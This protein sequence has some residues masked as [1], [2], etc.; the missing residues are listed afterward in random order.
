MG[1][2]RVSSRDD[3]TGQSSAVA[4][5]VEAAIAGDA[6][7]FDALVRR[8][9]D[10]AVGTAY[11][12][13]RDLEQ[14]EDAAQEAFIEVHR[15]LD[16]IVDTAAFPGFL[17]RVVLKHCDRRTRG[18]ARRFVPA[19]ADIPDARNDAA[20]SLVEREDQVRVRAALEGLP[21]DERLAV[22]LHYLGGLTQVEVADWLELPLSTVKKR[23]H[24]AR[25]RIRVAMETLVDQTFESMR[26]SR[27]Q[28]FS[29]T[30]RLFLAIREG[31]LESVTS[32]LERDPALCEVDERWSEEL[33]RLHGL[34][35]VNGGTPL[36]RAA[37]RDQVEMIDLLLA[38]GAQVDRCCPCAG[39]ESPLWAAV[40][41]G[42]RRAA[43]RLL[44]AGADPDAASFGGHA[45]LHVA[46][47]RG[48]DDIVELLCE[49][50][51]DGDRRDLHG[52]TPGDWA[53]LKG[54]KA[55][56]ERLDERFPGS[57]PQGDEQPVH[58]RNARR[59]GLGTGIKA[60]DLFAPFEPGSLVYTRY[61]AGMGAIVLLAE[62]SSRWSHAQRGAGAAVVWVGWERQPS[63][64]A[65]MQHAFA[66]LDLDGPVRLVWSPAAEDE[67]ARRQTLARAVRTANGLAADDG[68]DPLLVV[69]AQ[70]GRW[71]E[72]EAAL[73]LLGNRSGSA[74]LTTLVAERYGDPAADDRPLPSP[75]DARICFDPKLA[76]LGHFPAIHPFR[77][78]SRP[79]CL[80]EP[81]ASR[82]EQIAKGACALLAEH[83][84]LVPDCGDGDP[85]ELSD[86]EQRTVA[87]ARRLQAFLTQPFQVAESFTSRIGRGLFVEET[88][89][90]VEAILGGAL[91]DVDLGRV[92][93]RGGLR[94]ILADACQDAVQT[95]R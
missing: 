9:Q 37:E 80:A 62:L 85:D 8:F 89:A 91:D 90:D 29:D 64:L 60:L 31:D 88:L 6:A 73:P 33:T 7:A 43:E 61:D 30:I 68:V 27:D 54:R 24:T 77:T 35:A 19:E 70:P 26:P 34:P 42:K 44:A 48:F 65:E 79:G 5:W 12:W 55:I 69:F 25:G 93:Y 81:L 20:A 63:D 18:A 39:A 86:E 51:A 17:R 56:A 2:L 59:T 23:L 14:A 92:P 87:R 11:G 52:R 28:V 71:G 84:R 40:A 15:N 57:A 94:D 41:S 36:V 75:F 82:H 49:A 13:L 78:A 83:R 76:A 1:L 50:G 4:D 72:I 21:R 32:L 38:H 66:E 22:S 45:P 3:T 74:T 10:M 16:R 46:A 53:R 47:L 58:P 95:P 67:D